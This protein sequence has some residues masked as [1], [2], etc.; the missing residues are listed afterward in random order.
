MR[1]AAELEV[2]KRVQ[3]EDTS[4]LA[5]L[6]KALESA[7][8]VAEEATGAKSDSSAQSRATSSVPR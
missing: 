7:K 3:E 4:N 6:V 1:Y 8:L 5:Q 2:A